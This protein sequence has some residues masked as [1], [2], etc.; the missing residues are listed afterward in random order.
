MNWTESDGKLVRTFK[1]PDFLT[2]YNLV[3]AVVGPAQELNHHPD[4][5]FGW[6]YVRITLT[7]HDAGGI[8]DWIIGWPRPSTRPLNHSTY[9]SWQNATCSLI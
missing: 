8:T 7:T 3:G 5:A 9:D 2:A 4:I 6:G 1:T